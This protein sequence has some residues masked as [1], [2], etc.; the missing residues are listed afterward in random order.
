MPIT[1]NVGGVS[2]MLDSVQT[3]INGVMHEF[4]TVH[5][6]IDGVLHEIHSAW[7]K[8]NVTWTSTGDGTMTNSPWFTSSIDNYIISNEY[9]I[10]TILVPFKSDGSNGTLTA[11]VTIPNNTKLNICISS[12]A[13]NIASSEY[14]INRDSTRLKSGITKSTNNYLYTDAGEYSIV[15]HHFVGVVGGGSATGTS[16]LTIILSYQKI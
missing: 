13:G 9:D 8:P 2:Y 10:R 12:Q 16:G 15:V 5:H 7:K 11:K 6:N 4:N 14:T 1:D 3:N